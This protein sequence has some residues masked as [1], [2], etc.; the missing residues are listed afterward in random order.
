MD[1]VKEAI[2]LARTDT[3]RRKMLVGASLGMAKFLGIRDAKKI[4][5]ELGDTKRAN[6]LMLRMEKSF[7]INPQ[8]LYRNLVL[9]SKTD[10]LVEKA[11]KITGESYTM[12]QVLYVMGIPGVRNNDPGETKRALRTFEACVHSKNAEDVHKIFGFVSTYYLEGSQVFEF[13]GDR[14][15]NGNIVKK[16]RSEGGLVL[17]IKGDFF[18][19]ELKEGDSIMLT[20]NLKKRFAPQDYVKL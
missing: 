2:E 11:N 20:R 3:S 17:K 9:R 19:E 14:Q 12:A 7:N 1:M 5:E 18:K 13:V 6:A 4:F 8:Q 15:V 10:K 16:L